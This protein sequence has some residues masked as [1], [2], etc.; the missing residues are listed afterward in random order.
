MGTRS[1][2]P[3]AERRGFLRDELKP[4]ENMGGRNIVVWG[5]AARKARERLASAGVTV[6]E[7]ELKGILLKAASKRL[8]G[9]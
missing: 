5:T 6:D 4:L 7:D 1:S 9:T 3:T 8:T 2:Q